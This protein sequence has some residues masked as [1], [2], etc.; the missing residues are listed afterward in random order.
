M[1][2]FKYYA[3]LVEIEDGAVLPIAERLHIWV[4][5][6]RLEVVAQITPL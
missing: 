6:V 3:S 4:D 2:K 1:K 5:Q